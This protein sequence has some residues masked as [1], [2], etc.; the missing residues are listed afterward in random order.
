MTCPLTGFVHAMRH[1][2]TDGSQE[3]SVVR[4][5][6]IARSALEDRSLAFGFR[7]DPHVLDGAPLEHAC[8]VN[9]P[10]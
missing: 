10:S 9:F 8:R 2:W 1:A 4:Y 6:F 3:R 5:M 7:H